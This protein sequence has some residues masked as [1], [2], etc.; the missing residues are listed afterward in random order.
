M[1][2]RHIFIKGFYILGD[3]M[4]NEKKNET[5]STKEIILVVIETLLFLFSL[6]CVMLFLRIA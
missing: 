6:I 2:W 1:G 5:I 3:V 4:K